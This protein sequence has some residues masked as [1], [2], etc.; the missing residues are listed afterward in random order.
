MT[1][2]EQFPV[3]LCLKCSTCNTVCP[4]YQVEPRFLGPKFI[5][6]E[7]ARLTPGKRTGSTGLEYC[8][9]CRRCETVCPAG[10]KISYLSHQAKSIG[11]KAKRIA[12]RDLI[13]GHN[14]WFSSL[15]S[16]M[17]PVANLVLGSNVAGRM[18]QKVLH[19]QDRPLPKYSYP[20]RVGTGGAKREKPRGK[21][22]YFTGCYARYNHTQVA[23]T[24]MD[25]LTVLG[26][27]V[28]VPH[29]KCCGVPLMANG[30]MAAARKNAFYNVKILAGLVDRGYDIVTSC[31]SCALS[32]KEDY[33]RY[34]HL[35]NA[36]KVAGKVYD[37]SQYILHVAGGEAGGI[38]LKPVAQCFFY[39]QPCHTK[40]QGIGS[41]S[42]ALLKL[43]PGL[44]LVTG[45]QKCCGQAGTYGFK[46][47][48]YH[49]AMAIGRNRFQDVEQSAVSGIVTE[50]G[51]CGLQLA[52]GTGKRVYH[53][54]EI[55]KQALSTPEISS[56]KSR[57]N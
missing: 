1:A 57:D 34:F 20:F 10:V 22:A 44:K 24:V 47:E 30:L 41:P 31:P 35:P 56:R 39:H 2:K 52:Q 21:V 28:V 40:V 17:A 16:S 54:L 26:V 43:V 49:I 55:L 7:L 38:E 42:A 37:L 9:D 5:G 25:V 3:D 53:P 51:M 14:Q 11:Q 13:L 4:V 6:P 27:K 46:K 12:L 48:K 29:Q 19:I 8:M 50:C 15:A 36:A 18:A 32:L 33:N 23:R 45:E